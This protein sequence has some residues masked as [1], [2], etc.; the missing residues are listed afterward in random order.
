MEQMMTIIHFP[1]Q[2]PVAIFLVVLGIILLAPIVFNKLKIPHIVGMIIA[3]IFVGPYG[4]N[5]LARDSSF[6]I[7]GQVGI[8]YLMFLAAV[9]IDMFNLR[10]NLR[11]GVVFGLITFLL[12]MLIG[13]PVVRYCFDVS[14]LSAALISSM[15]A[16][17]TLISYPIIN[18]FG[19]QNTR[20]VV[21]SVCGTIVAVLLALVVLAEVVSTKNTGRFDWQSIF[22]LGFAVLVYVI[23]IGWLYPV[24][25]RW[26]FRNVSDQVTQFI[27]ILAM[28]FVASVLAQLIGLEAILGAF[29]AGLVLNRFIPVRSGLMNRIVFV[30][31][32][33]FIPYFLI[34]VGM[35]INVHVIF[36][37]WSVVYG[38]T[39][40]TATAL[41]C[42]WL[43][44]YVTQK[45]Y[46]F[47]RDGRN[48]L[49][50]LTSGK[51][52]ATIAAVM[53]GYK[54]DL[55]SENLMNGAVLMIL[56]C[57]LVASIVTER[58]AIRRRIRITGEDLAEKS[59]GNV[60]YGRQLVAVANPITAEGIMKLAVLMRSTRNEHPITALFVRNN[61]DGERRAVGK[62]ALQVA[63]DTAVSADLKVDGVERYDINIV[64][65]ITNVMKERDSTEIIIGLHRKSNIVDT[66]YGSLIEQ[67]LRSTN[68]MIV[69]SRCYIP[70]N[71]VRNIYILVPEKAE[72]ETGFKMWVARVSQL[73]TQLG[74]KMFFYSNP[75]TAKY[76]QGFIST[77]DYSPRHQF[78]DMQNWDDFIMLSRDIKEDDLMIVIGARRTSISFSADLENLPGFLSRYYSRQNLVVIYPE[79]FGDSVDMPAPIDPLAQPAPGIVSSFAVWF[80][81]LRGTSLERRMKQLRMLHR[82]SR[83]R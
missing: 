58:S 34:G 15:F 29:Y 22:R 59:K 32:A 61:D 19:L 3:G 64:S 25:T 66:F 5:I 26:F 9:E 73:G 57:C 70:V 76:I 40:M 1:L 38:A 46:G 30:G 45:I 77:R 78:R 28:V 79:Q 67:M 21:I 4:F 83:K 18:R 41:G 62:N 23:S 27:Y 74:A 65:G 11:P 72:Y 52:A 68:R 12:P 44:S 17:H 7:F 31:N 39:V 80:R 63:I 54:Y 71:T 37:G 69:M 35:L 50:G 33:I 16:S 47:T 20:S 49:F 2:Q 82:H 36:N 42:K 56:I 8:L 81:K 48:I 60:K 14:W 51:A 10:K 75:V 55:I 43:A 53:V 24:V 6:E 13:L